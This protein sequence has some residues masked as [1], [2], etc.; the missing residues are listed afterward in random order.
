MTLTRPSIEKIFTEY[1]PEDVGIHVAYG[2][3]KEFLVEVQEAF[4]SDV[5]EDTTKYAWMSKN[6]VQNHMCTY[7]LKDA[8]SGY[9]HSGEAFHLMLDDDRR[10]YIRY[11]GD[12]RAQVSRVQELASFA[13]EC[14]RR[15]ERQLALR[16]RREKV[17]GFKQAAMLAQ[18][19]KLASEEEFDFRVD[20]TVAR[21]K[22]WIRSTDESNVIHIHFAPKRFQEILPQLPGMIR[23]LRETYAAGVSYKV[24]S[25]QGM[26]WGA[27]WIHHRGDTDV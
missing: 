14:Q 1:F 17:R 21:V 3:R 12:L 18:L 19:K 15:Y 6:D 2:A 27:K 10:L 25:R 8:S 16:Q 7:T 13:Q 9:R 11:R 4:V 26:P 22:L 24:M 5:W 23:V 20:F